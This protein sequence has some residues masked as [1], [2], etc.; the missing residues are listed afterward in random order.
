LQQS[1]TGE[2]DPREVKL[3]RAPFLPDGEGIIAQDKRSDVLGQSSIK[4]SVPRHDFSNAD[5]ANQINW[6]SELPMFSNEI[7]LP[8]RLFQQALSA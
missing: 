3:L 2:A 6:A 4:A 5:R 8:C 7:A 1:S